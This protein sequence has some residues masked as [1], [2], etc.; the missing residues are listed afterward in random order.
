MSSILFNSQ[1]VILKNFFAQKNATK[2]SNS[3]Q[4]NHPN[5]QL[6]IKRPP[7]PISSHSTVA[8]IRDSVKIYVAEFV[9]TLIA[10]VTVVAVAAIVVTATF[11][12]GEF[13][14]N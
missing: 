2:T 13:T 4:N 8:K 9:S 1:S 6:T 3:L 11:D 5:E 7:T 10:V 14:V 12:A